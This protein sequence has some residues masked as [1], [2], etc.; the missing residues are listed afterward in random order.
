MSDKYSRVWMDEK[1]L[2]IFGF[3][4]AQRIGPPRSDGRRP[5]SP[6]APHN[7]SLCG[8]PTQGWPHDP[9]CRGSR[10]TPALRSM[11]MLERPRAHLA[12][13]A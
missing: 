9:E 3:R 10:N 8:P 12:Q 11:M 13:G 1:A 6:Y 5:V 2:Q 7:S 4:D